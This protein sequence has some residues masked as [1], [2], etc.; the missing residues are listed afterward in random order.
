MQGNSRGAVNLMMGAASRVEPLATIDGPFGSLSLTFF[1]NSQRETNES[2][3]ASGWT[4]G[5][6]VYLKQQPGGDGRWRITLPNGEEEYF[7]C[8]GWASNMSCVVDDHH[9]AG[10][11]RR[12]SDVFYYYPGDGTRYSF[13][14]TSFTT[15]RLFLEH[16][17]GSGFRIALS[18]PDGSERPTKIETENTSIYYH[19]GYDASGVSTVRLNST[20]AKQLLDVDVTDAGGGLFTLDKIKFASALDTIS[21]DTYLA[22]GYASSTQ[23]LT[24][25]TQKL[26]GGAAAL[27]TAEATYDGSDRVTAIKDATKNLEIEYTSSSKTTVDFNVTGSDVATVEFTHNKHYVTTRNSDIQMGGPQTRTQVFDQHGRTICL[28]TDDSRMTKFIFA[29]STRP[30]R[31]DVYGKSGDCTSG[32]TVDHKIWNSWG[33]NTSVQAL[34]L[35]WTRRTSAF[36]GSSD[37]SSSANNCLE[38]KYEYVSPTD[39]RVETSTTTGYTKLINDTTPTLVR[40]RR[41]Y[42]YGLDSSVCPSSGDF[43]DRLL[44]QVETRNSAGTVFARSKY[45]Y[46]PGGAATSG[47]LK[48]EKRYDSSSDAAPQTTSYASHNDFGSPTSVTSPAGV[49][50]NYTYNGWNAATAVTEN[51]G[52]LTDASPP[53]TQDRSWSY[54]YNDLRQLATVTLP[55]GNK[56]IRKYYTGSTDYAR[57][58]AYATA[59][60]SSNL[61]EIKKYDYDLFGNRTEEKII[62]SIA[63]SDDETS[64]TWE[65]RR[66][67][68][69]NARRQLLNTYLHAADT[70]DPAD[71]TATHSYTSGQ[72]TNIENYLAMDT[73]TIY[74]DQGRTS[75]VEVDDGGVSATTTYTYDIH[76]RILTTTS[77]TGVVTRTEYDDFGQL[78]L[79]RSQTRGDLRY[80][81]DV[82]GRLTERRRSS[83]NSSS[84]AERT[85]YS[86]DW[87]GRKLAVDISCNSSDDA[88]F[89]YDGD[90]H[91]SNSCPS[92]AKQTGRLSFYTQGG[93]ANMSKV[94]CYHPNGMLYSAHQ[95]D[96]STFSTSAAKGTTR[97]YDLN[98]NI[99]K[100]YLHDRPDGHAYAREVEYSYHADLEDR[101]SK[102]RH[103]LTS[104][105]SWT[106]VT[107]SSTLI[108]YFPFG[109]I[110]SMKLGNG[111][112][113]TNTRDKGY[114][115]T[116]REA[117][118]SGTDFTDINLDYDVGGNI[119]RYQD[120]A[121]IRHMTY[122]ATYDNLNRLRCWSRASISACTGTE[123]WED[124]F[125]ESFDYDASGNRTNRRFGAFNTTDDDA[126]TYVSSSDIIDKVTS[127]GTD[128]QMS[129]ASEAKSHR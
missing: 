100:E 108:T 4:N 106:D 8:T 121:D 124:K 113:E 122:Y 53:S 15:A 118:Y 63:D 41:H 80:E 40:V 65:V 22:Y 35:A 1:Y 102:V 56:I 69:Y 29:D 2:G 117:S 9:I 57:L 129:T 111:I 48:S 58:K 26:S 5:L 128:K 60:G 20:S 55:K 99:E 112:I 110:K 7:R 62:D 109:G 50:T 11:L 76:G 89:Y 30:T 31:I 47:L 105:G 39:N 44:C 95:R 61:L 38:T 37:C 94:L 81:Y 103:R 92:A 126:Y 52:L 45:E 97:I 93:A 90:S 12:I 119:T 82:A 6:T 68:K 88:N 104:A 67:W 21:T 127:G 125:L 3:I 17:D 36:S 74:D 84:N 115:L 86:Y 59:D 83:Y 79:D 28:E 120:L 25:V 64:S 72:V 54:E 107:D 87:L 85:C 91:P 34:R 14:D 77:P 49:V 70:S 73:A 23:N 51:D 43:Y 98:G 42:Y 66:Q 78:V 24:A 71:A 32:G 10:N 96:S 123:P 116:N 18:T 19:F 101:V 27:T 114:R 75:T 16:I 13:D 46:V 33:Y